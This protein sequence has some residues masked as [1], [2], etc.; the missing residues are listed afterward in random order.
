MITQ[1][2][3][4]AI[5]VDYHTHSS[6]GSSTQ[7]FTSHNGRS[8]DRIEQEFEIWL[9][10]TRPTPSRRLIRCEGR[11]PDPWL[12]ETA[13]IAKTSERGEV[14]FLGY[15]AR[16][17]HIEEF[18]SFEPT[19]KE[20]AKVVVDPASETGLDDYW[21]YL[22][23]RTI[24]QAARGILWEG[25][26]PSSQEISR[27][28]VSYIGATATR[29]SKELELPA[30][31]SPYDHFA[32]SFDRI[33]PHLTDVPVDQTFFEAETVSCL[34]KL[35][36][37]PIQQITHRVNR[38]REAHIARVIMSD[39]EYGMQVFSTLGAPHRPFMGGVGSVH[40]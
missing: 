3:Q 17:H 29:I 7:I 38:H 19:L 33:Y 15:L 23:A 39:M 4:E 14:A 20:Q 13:E 1:A 10:D 12:C 30:D 34:N 36:E 40:Y 25:G 27:R 8:Y 24:P 37:G 26:Q 32:S 11:V 35:P 9:D 21:Y 2:P 22:V 28:L 31:E 5:L 18:G 6:G 16:K